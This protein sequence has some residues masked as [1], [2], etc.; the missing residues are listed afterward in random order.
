MQ[1]SIVQIIA[2]ELTIHKPQVEATINLLDDGAT[3]PF[4]ARYRKEITQGLDDSQLRQLEERLASLRELHKRRETILNSIESQ[5]K[6]TDALKQRLFDAQTRTV[7]EDL[8]LPYKP[9]RRTKAQIAREAGLQP[10]ADRLLAERHLDLH[11][12][13][14]AFIKPDDPDHAIPDGQAALTGAQHILMETF[15]ENADLMSELRHDLWEHGVLSSTKIEQKPPASTDNDATSNDAMTDDK[16]SA[17]TKTT[18]S[19]KKKNKADKYQD[20]FAY[21]EAIKRIPSHRALALFRGQAETI[22]R[23]R[24]DWAEQDEQ[25]NANTHFIH[26]CEQK[27]AKAYQI[28]FHEQASQ[29]DEH[30]TWLVDT[31]RRAWRVKIHSKLETDLKMQLR[32]SAEQEAIHVFARNLKDLLLTAPAGAKVTLGLDPGLRTGVKFAIIDQTGKVLDTGAIYPHAPRKE[33]DKSI[34][35]LNELVRRHNVELISI[36]NGTASRET[37]RLISE[38]LKRHNDLTITKLVV[39]EAGAS[40]YSASAAASKELPELDVSLRGAVSIARRLQDPLAELVKIEPKAIGVG[41]YQ[42]DV[43][44]IRLN[45]SL[46]AV[47]EDCVNAVGVDVNTASAALLSAI[48]GLNRG[49]ADN[50]VSHR[51]QHGAF[52]NRQALL[53]VNRMGAKAFEQAAGFLRI[54]N[55]DNRLD[56]SAVHPEA[57][58]LVETIAV[59]S[60]RSIQ[61]LVGDSALLKNLSAKDF[62]TEQ[63]GLPTINDILQELD[64]PGRDPR[65][66]FTTAQFKEGVEELSDLEVGMK[67]EGI[68][69]NVTNFGAFVDIGVHQDGLVHISAL[70]EQFVK[71]PHDIVK[72][73]DIV[74]VYVES[75][76]LTRKRIALSMK[77]PLA[78]KATTNDSTHTKPNHHKRTNRSTE[79]AINQPKSGKNTPL[80]K[81]A[82]NK[83]TKN[84]PSRAKQKKNEPAIQNSVMA[85][86]FL[87]AKK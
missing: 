75:V 60:Q 65:P 3:V 39:S 15:A 30:Q 5:G 68:V 82:N 23:L 21:Q 53:N 63:F 33:W 62:V 20:Y 31:V 42:H 61:D 19:H 22:L 16:P 49:L 50:I 11:E 14:Q 44:Q 38:L 9:K 55:G 71:D 1:A 12:I 74:H 56:A 77:K 45:K 13:A 78:E 8:Y 47:V 83:S 43:N 34:Q 76:D 84:N 18:K 79:K 26:P 70:S 37:D 69:S 58:P 81:Q 28:D 4:I 2:N 32:E 87:N 35:T 48:A 40:V 10:L 59:K 41:Q 46:G 27:I 72:A 67:L 66:A 52:S 54:L 86:A 64:K 6:L 24:L 17:Q 85:D 7:L 51:N 73:G 80:I 36:G 25:S 29:Q 57:Y